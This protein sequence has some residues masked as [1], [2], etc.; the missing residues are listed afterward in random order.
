MTQRQRIGDILVRAGVI[1]EFQLR[2]ALGEQQR[3]GGRLGVTL[4][5]LGFL[6]ETDLVRALASQLD[7]PVARLE[8]KRIEPEVLALVPAEA[9]ERSMCL[10]L[11]VKKESG[12]KVLYVGMED[13][14]DLAALDEMS[15]RAGMQVRPVLMG[16][17]ELC[18]GI[19]R[20]YRHTGPEAAPPSR[21]GAGQAQREGPEADGEATL[22]LVAREPES[23]QKELEFVPT[24]PNSTQETTIALE[25]KPKEVLRAI[26][27][28]LIE[29]GLIGREELGERLRALQ[30]SESGD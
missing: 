17:S 19:D 10:P 27:H 3:W 12:S 28:L 29:K 1:D 8:G 25:A 26:T 23:D 5:K 9:A 2:S 21:S 16:P 14:C 18:E 20:F 24:E 22:E 13:P 6:E 15:F 30:E 11:F 4:I 7:M